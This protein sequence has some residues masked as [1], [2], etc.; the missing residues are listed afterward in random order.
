MVVLRLPLV[1]GPGVRANFLALLRLAASPWPLPLAGARSRRSML[2]LDNAVDA[3]LHAACA[4]DLGGRAFFVSD[5][6][7]QSVAEWIASIRRAQGRT[8]SLFAV[9]Q[10]MLR[11]SATALGRR[12]KHDRLFARALVDDTA[13]RATGWHPPVDVD[14]GIAHTLAWLAGQGRS[15]G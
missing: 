7:G 14:T 8:P 13:F 12:N 2:Y 9:P 15:A 5:G 11:A 10:T 1:W 4:P 3:L 6:T